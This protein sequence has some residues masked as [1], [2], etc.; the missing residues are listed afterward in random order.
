MDGRQ[1][2]VIFALRR[3]YSV[4]YDEW[5][6]QAHWTSNMGMMSSHVSYGDELATNH[7]S[8]SFM[9]IHTHLTLSHISLPRKLVFW[10]NSRAHCL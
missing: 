5:Y 2:V 7:F 4:E 8:V 9:V 10:F 1:G 3:T 6:N